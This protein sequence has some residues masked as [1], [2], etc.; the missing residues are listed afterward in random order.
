MLR[1]AFVMSVH[2][3]QEQ[4]YQRATIHLARV[5]E[6]LSAHGVTTIPFLP[7]EN[8]QLFAYVEIDDEERWKPSPGRPCASA[9][10]NTWRY[11]AG[12]ADIAPWRP[13][14]EGGF[15]PGLRA[16]KTKGSDPLHS[17]V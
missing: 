8:H 3:G 6:V 10:G 9:G 4:E 5:A 14:L 2:P 7:S 11:H 13:G 15:S 16:A 1:K 12:D 17:R